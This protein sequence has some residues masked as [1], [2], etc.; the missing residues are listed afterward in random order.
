MMGLITVVFGVVV[1]VYL[2]NNPLEA[3]FLDDE[4]KK[5]VL[6]NIRENETGTENKTFK[7]AHIYELF[8]HDKHTWP[9]FIL[10]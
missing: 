5:V 1:F 2:P 4:Q 8:F 6:N 7:K 10:T 3:T 9:M